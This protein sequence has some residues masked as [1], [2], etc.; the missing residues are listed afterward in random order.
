MDLTA[1]ASAIAVRFAAAAITP[2]S[3]YTDP[4]TA[5]WQLPGAI[6]TTPIAIVFPPEGEL[7]HWAFKRTANFD[8]PVR[9]YVA[10]ADSERGTKALYDWSSVLIS[11][12]QVDYDLNL[13]PTVTHAVVT[14]VRFGKLEYAGQEFYGLELAVRVHIEEAFTPT[15]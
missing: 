8:F 10:P 6:S 4:G 12:L 13:S 9:W 2:P 7:S 1:C 15:T 11:Q 14:G 5:V 3:G